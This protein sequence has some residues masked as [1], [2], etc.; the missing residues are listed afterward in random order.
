MSQ[1]GVAYTVEVFILYGNVP[2]GVSWT[3]SRL[4]RWRHKDSRLGASDRWKT[5]RIVKNYTSYQL[6]VRED[7]GNTCESPLTK[8]LSL[9][10]ADGA[11]LIACSNRCPTES[12]F[13]FALLMELSD[14]GIF[15]PNF[16]PCGLARS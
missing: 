9:E 13:Y 15:N 6:R 10:N 12:R 5:G 7:G 14:G 8:Y 1:R 3:P 2:M 16:R 11:T 4:A